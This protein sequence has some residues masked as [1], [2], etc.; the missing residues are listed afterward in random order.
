VSVCVIC[1][2]TTAASYGDH[3]SDWSYR[4]LRKLGA[5]CLPAR[6]E[7]G[8]TVIDPPFVGHVVICCCC[9]LQIGE[10]REEVWMRGLHTAG[11][12]DGRD[13]YT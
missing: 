10:K 2:G 12:D 13:Y 11:I 4:T 6:S 1:D 5:V 7:D 3:Y 8:K 9:P